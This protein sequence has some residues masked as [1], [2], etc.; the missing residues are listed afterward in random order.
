MAEPES[1]NTMM[2]N[3]YAKIADGEYA[4]RTTGSSGGTAQTVSLDPAGNTVKLDQNNPNNVVR[5][6]SATNTVKLDSANNTVKIDQTGSNNVVATNP[7]SASNVNSL[8]DTNSVTSPAADA[9]IATTANLPAGT[10]DL[11]AIT[12]ISG[13]TVAATEVTNMRLRVGT[14]AIG[15]I[16]NPVPGTTGGVATGQLRCRFIAPGGQAANIIAVAAGTTGAIYSA[17][18]VARRVL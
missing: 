5:I 16:L 15:R 9:V 4:L 14:T 13:T 7:N 17:S 18:I 6:D 2:Q 3:S 11:E 8:T 12:Y 10:Y 1:I